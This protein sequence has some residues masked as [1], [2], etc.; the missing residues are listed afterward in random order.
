MRKHTNFWLNTHRQQWRLRLSCKLDEYFSRYQFGSDWLS[1]SNSHA[2]TWV[3]NLATSADRVWKKISKFSKTKQLF[4]ETSHCE[5]SS[6]NFNSSNINFV[7]NRVILINRHWRTLGFLCSH[8]E[9]SSGGKGKWRLS[10]GRV[11]VSVDIWVIICIITDL[12]Q[13]FQLQTWSMLYKE[14]KSCALYSH[15]L[16]MRRHICFESRLVW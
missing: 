13:R 3:L 14:G 10:C 4:Q 8:A 1:P 6:K 16:L 11:Y 5:S 15:G 7:N 12:K 9:E 2:W